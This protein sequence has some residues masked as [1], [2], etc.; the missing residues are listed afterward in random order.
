MPSAASPFG[1]RV[2]LGLG[3]GLLIFG[4]KAKVKPNAA[5]AAPSASASSA[6]IL[7]AAPERCRALGTGTS[8]VVGEVD[9]PAREPGAEPD[10][11]DADDE[12]AL[13]P[14]ATR[15]DSAF[16]LGN[17]FAVG[18]LNTQRAKTEAFL[19]LVPL[20]GSPGRRVGLGAVHGDVDPPLVTGEDD[21]LLVAVADMDAGGGMLRI[22]AAD[23]HADKPHGEL[24]ITGVEHDTGAAFAMGEHGAL[25]VWGARGKRGAVLKTLAVKPD[26]LSGTA[27]GDELKG[28]DGAE[29]PAL[30]ARPGGFWLAWVSEQ[31]APAAHADA[32][33]HDPVPH[34]A[35]TRNANTHDANARDA[36]AQQ[37]S[38]DGPERLVDVGPRALMVLSLDAN[39]KPTGAPRAVSGPRA[40]VVGFSAALL[41]DA[42]L[43]LT[44]REDDAA[45]GVE[46]G[47]PELARVGL[48][49]AVQRAKVEDEE[50]SAGL[51]S[52]VAD[53]KPGGDVWVAL[54][55]ASEGTRVGV[56]SPTGLKLEALV[57]DRLL[58]G[59]DLLAAADKKLLVSRSRGRAVELGV[60]ECKL[61]P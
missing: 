41:P 35:G 28:T 51:P 40:H 27:P 15:V 45:P 47:P 10:T 3:A 49:G 16:V 33:V 19:A 54:E 1:R 12:E 23:V 60:L 58:R 46:S 11:D 57:G 59:A 13:Q 8:L 7:A 32:G 4:C 25:L 56:L 50:L 9:R 36:G 22:S 48:D 34:D 39:G 29:S 20:D 53:P 37:G 55:S 18:G 21:T 6:P 30:V 17:D 14:F 43:S 61:Q 31:A 26:K 38:G 5:P 52:L 24:S 42:A 2:T 44:W